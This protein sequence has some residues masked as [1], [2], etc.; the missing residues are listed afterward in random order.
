MY[1]LVLQIPGI[2]QS[3]EKVFTQQ[4]GILAE[5]RFMGIEYRVTNFENEPPD[6]V[7]KLAA[8]FNLKITRI[9][10]GAMAVKEKLSLSD[11]GDVGKKTIARLKD[12]ADYAAQF[13]AGLILG[14]I[15]GT[16]GYDREKAKHQFVENLSGV[17]DYIIK[18]N[19]PLIIEATNHYETSVAITLAD[20]VELVKAISSS[21]SIKEPSPLL[22]ILPDTYHMN[23]EEV[24]TEAE[25][26]KYIRHF[27]AI[28]FSDNNRYLPGYGAIDFKKTYTALSA[29]NFSGYIG[30]EGNFKDLAR[31]IALCSDLVSV[32]ER[33]M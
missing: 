12:L 17:A 28:H 21:V 8:D 7:K 14:F 1:P 5:H 26:Y 31:D 23:I 33:G 29:A 30:L 16:A 9:S 15:K 3:G 32:I 10:T 6:R 22:Q 2:E 4:L 18:K 19:L 25:L 13:N 20:A 27:E 24:N 11:G